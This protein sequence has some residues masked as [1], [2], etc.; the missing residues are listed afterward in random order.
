[1]KPSVIHRIHIHNRQISTDIFLG[2][3]I[4]KSI[5]KRIGVD[6]NNCIY[7]YKFILSNW[8]YTF[9]YNGVL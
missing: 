1:M 2:L 5:N 7:K 4:G 9:L 3:E 6:K 8:I